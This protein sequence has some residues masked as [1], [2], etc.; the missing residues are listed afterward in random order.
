MMAVEKG[1]ILYTLFKR[2]RKLSRG[3][4][5]R[6]PSP[7]VQLDVTSPFL[8]PLDVI[9]DV[10]LTSPVVYVYKLRTTGQQFLQRLLSQFY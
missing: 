10:T 4:D 3:R 1:N 7:A 5:V 8:Q 9:G 2:K 6:I